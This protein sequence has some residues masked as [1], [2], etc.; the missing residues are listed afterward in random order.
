MDLLGRWRRRAALLFVAS[1]PLLLAGCNDAEAVGT[2]E[3]EASSEKNF[4]LE[5]QKGPE[6]SFFYKDP[7]DQWA[8][9][10]WEINNA[11]DCLS[12]SGGRDLVGDVS[13][14]FVRG[15]FDKLPVNII[16]T[17]GRSAYMCG[18]RRENMEEIIYRN[19]DQL[20]SKFTSF[21]SPTYPNNPWTRAYVEQF[22]DDNELEL[23]HPYLP[24]RT[25]GEALEKGSLATLG[26][27][28]IQYESLN[29][30]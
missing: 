12:V 30:G 28:L 10:C 29:S 8:I 6:N 25:I 11:F 4:E 15:S 18:Y 19:G 14:I 5:W 7:E 2:Q 24:C 23:S 22:V 27:T 13:Y 20:I 3:R 1:G 26:T 17:G 16:T 9:R 21:Y